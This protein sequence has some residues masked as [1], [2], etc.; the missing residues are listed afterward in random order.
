MIITCP[1]CNKKFNIDVSLI[2]EKGRLLQCGSCNHKWH[3]IISKQGSENDKNI[4][5][6]NKDNESIYINK[7]PQEEQEEKVNKIK[8]KKNSK[9][10]E[11]IKN[12]NQ[13]LSISTKKNN[14]KYSLGNLLGN[15]MIILITF[16][17]LILII[18]TFKINIS[19]YFP[20]IIPLLDSLYQ[21]LID[22]ISFINDLIN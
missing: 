8:E 22:L 1:N 13:E 5:I 11:K 4:N 3:Y 7:L 18:D 19:N 12:K 14:K 2:S 17:A 20:L 10:Q 21:S 9:I 6:Q 16:F 15:L